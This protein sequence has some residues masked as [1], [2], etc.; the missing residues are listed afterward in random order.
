MQHFRILTDRDLLSRSQN[1]VANMWHDFMNN[2]WS[3]FDAVVVPLTFVAQYYPT[4]PGVGVLRLLRVLRVL[5]LFQ[6]LRSLRVIIHA[7][8]KS[9]V[10]VANAFLVLILVSHM[11]RDHIATNKR[12]GLCR[13]PLFSSPRRHI[14]ASNALLHFCRTIDAQAIAR[15]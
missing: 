13:C 12:P 9:I 15:R 10:P 5:K 2:G 6:R 1:L 4:I 11:R 7:L 8:I 14:R 3:L